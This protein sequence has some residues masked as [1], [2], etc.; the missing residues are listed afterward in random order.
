MSES[1]CDEERMDDG[2]EGDACRTVFEDFTL[3]NLSCSAKA[4]YTIINVP[5]M[6][7]WS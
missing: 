7:L 3:F 1:I 4:S 5:V 6:G 2:E